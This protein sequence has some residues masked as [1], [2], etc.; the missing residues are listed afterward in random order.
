MKMIVMIVCAALTL[1]T[2]KAIKDSFEPENC[3]PL[4]SNCHC[5]QNQSP[6]FEYPW[7]CIEGALKLISGVY[8][9][10]KRMYDEDEMYDAS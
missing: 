10:Q 3:C 1:G 8:S 6:V 4:S 2:A 9:D 7:E 5:P